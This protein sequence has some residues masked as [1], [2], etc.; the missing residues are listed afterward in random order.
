MLGDSE[1]LAS[2]L[3][4]LPP[5]PGALPALLQ[6]LRAAQFLLAPDLPDEPLSLGALGI[7]NWAADDARA[8]VEQGMARGQ[9]AS[10][11]SQHCT[12]EARTVRKRVDALKKSLAELE[13]RHPGAADGEVDEVEG[14]R[15]VGVGARVGVGGVGGPFF[16]FF[17][18]FFFLWMN[19]SYCRRY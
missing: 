13:E 9:S 18:F 7:E 14:G 5:P 2:L 4:R 19:L 1:H 8:A 17:F 3:P 6:K 11:M 10:E 12:T 15:V 16:F